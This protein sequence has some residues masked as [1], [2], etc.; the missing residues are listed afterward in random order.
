[1]KRKLTRKTIMLKLIHI[2]NDTHLNAD[3]L[4]M[5]HDD[6]DDMALSFKCKNKRNHETHESTQHNCRELTGK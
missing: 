5:A 4:G 6:N 2:T 3:T 1:M